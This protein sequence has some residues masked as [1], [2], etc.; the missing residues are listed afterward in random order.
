MVEETSLQ[1]KLYELLELDEAR[2]LADFHQ[3]VEQRKQKVWHDRHIKKKAFTFEGHVLLYDSK[4]LK[5]L[6]KLHMH[7]LAS[8][9]F[10]KIEF[11]AFKLVQLDE[12]LLLWWV[13]GACLKPF[14]TSN[15][16]TH[17]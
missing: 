9:I 15:I 8:F 11:G 5:F 13:N 2:F 17:N 6:G 1:E 14:H 16:A 12:V 3:M 10:E 7:W 4:F